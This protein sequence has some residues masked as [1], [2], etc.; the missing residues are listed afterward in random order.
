[1]AELYR[2]KLPDVEL[3]YKPRFVQK[4]RTGGE[5]QAVQPGVASDLPPCIEKLIE[6]L[7]RGENL[8]HFAR[9]ALAAFLVN[10]GWDVGQIVDLF[11]NAPDFDEK[12]TRYQVEHI[13]GKRGGGRRYTPPSCER[14]RQEGLCVANCGISNPIEWLRRRQR[15]MAQSS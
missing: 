3:P 6:D 2:R 7:Q 11:R 9:F 1:M 8:S 4:P 13:A 5:G 10:A 15:N 12:V 14:M